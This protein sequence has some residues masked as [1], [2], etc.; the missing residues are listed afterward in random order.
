MLM[1][2]S[3]MSGNRTV[4]SLL[5]L[6]I[7]IPHSSQLLFQRRIKTMGKP[8]GNYTLV[9]E[10]SFIQRLW[11]LYHRLGIWSNILIS[12]RYCSASGCQL[13]KPAVVAALRAVVKAHPALW[14]VF[15]QRPSSKKGR[16]TLHIAALRVLDLEKCIVYLDGADNAGVTS[17]LLE[18]IHNEWEWTADEPERPWWKLLVKGRNIVFVYHHSVGDGM[19]GVVFHREFL[20]ALNSTT[21]DNLERPQKTIL[22]TTML[23]R[24]HWSQRT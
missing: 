18:A 5:R 12:A 9:R 7:F 3:V 21:A 14:H 16:H 1:L 22:S 19:S 6:L 15:V 8:T 2:S 13:I 17:E 11:Y 20:A 24:L 4:I 23:S 10:T